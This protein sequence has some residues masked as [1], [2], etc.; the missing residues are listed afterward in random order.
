[1]P[2]AGRVF[3]AALVALLLAVTVPGAVWAANSVALRISLPPLLNSLPIAYAKQWGLFEAHGITVELIGITD[4]QE[5]STALLTG[6]LDAVMEDLTRALLDASSG[7]ELVITAAAYQQ[8]EWADRELAVLSPASFGIDSFEALVASNYT[9]ATVFCSDHEY[10]LDQLLQTMSYRPMRDVSYTYWTDLLQMAVWVGSRALPAAVLPEPY[11]AYIDTFEPLQG[12]GIDLVPLADFSGIDSLPSVIVF[13]RGYVDAHPEAVEA[14][15]RAYDEAVERINA[16]EK[17]ELIETGL[18]VVL[19]LFFQGADP[20]LIT[21]DVLD[22]V[23]IPK[24]RLP[25]G[26][27]E[28]QFDAV[29]EWMRSR[30]YI[31]SAPALDSLF[32]DRFLP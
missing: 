9:I 17:D 31:R 19:S 25:T 14:F 10:M 27:D 3:V 1:M 23:S 5:R 4:S 6:N 29:A 12:T 28:Q 2:Y 16:S 26:L 15:H 22:A 8:P 7:G 18:A 32:D 24:Y 30:G 20:D 21:Q 13:R 11:I